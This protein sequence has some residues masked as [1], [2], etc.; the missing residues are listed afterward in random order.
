[1]PSNGK[2]FFSTLIKVCGL[3]VLAPLLLATAQLQ[4]NDPNMWVDP[5]L[6]VDGGGNTVPG[7]SVPFGFVSVSP[8]TSNANSSGYD[9]DGLILGFSHTH[10]SGTGGASKYG[11]FRVTPTIGEV[12]VNNLAFRKSHE[13]AAP[14]IYSVDLSLLGK[15]SVHAELTVSRRSAM[16]RY[17]YP[18]GSSGNLVLDVTSVIPLGGEPNAQRATNA[19]VTIID[20][21]TISG[22]ASFIGGWNP[23]PYRIYFFCHV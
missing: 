5:F 13:L 9:S 20:D 19:D 11:N 6:G 15:P 21:H 4:A 7:A 2:R 12:T 23:A 14:G 22:S 8:D 1:M 16:E 3:I 18:K 17:T 10:V